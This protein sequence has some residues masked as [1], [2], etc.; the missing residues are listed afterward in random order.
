MTTDV[1]SLRKPEASCV[2][3]LQNNFSVCQ[4]HICFEN[5]FVK[6]VSI[7]KIENSNFHTGL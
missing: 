3:A 7:S 6:V 5:I 4:S 2:N 1:L